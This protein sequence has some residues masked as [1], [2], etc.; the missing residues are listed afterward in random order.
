ML[1]RALQ[2]WP[3]A[4]ISSHM[5]LSAAA[6]SSEI[7]FRISGCG[8]C[9]ALFS[10]YTAWFKQDVSNPL[11]SPSWHHSH[12]THATAANYEPSIGSAACRTGLA[13]LCFTTS[14]HSGGCTTRTFLHQTVS[15]AY[16]AASNA[17]LM[18]NKTGHMG[19]NLTVKAA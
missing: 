1:Y 14:Q 6:S 12:R 19:V 9:L 13:K 3:K 7:Q 15:G 11:A 2:L 10:P 5:V 18:P 4:H 16:K 17:K 8:H